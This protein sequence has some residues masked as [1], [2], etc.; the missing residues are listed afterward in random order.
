MDKRIGILP[1]SVTIIGI[2]VVFTAAKKMSDWP[3]CGG[4]ASAMGGDD[5]GACFALSV[6]AGLSIAVMANEPGDG[7][8]VPP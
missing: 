3:E 7:T 8:R 4:R 2:R 6:S 5:T 1:G